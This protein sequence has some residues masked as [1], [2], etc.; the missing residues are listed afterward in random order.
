MLPEIKVMNH[1]CRFLCPEMHCGCHGLSRMFLKPKIASD[2]SLLQQRFA[3]NCV[4]SVLL[5]Q[6]KLSLLRCYVIPQKILFALTIPGVVGW[7]R[8]SRHF[9]TFAVFYE[10]DMISSNNHPTER[11][12]EFVDFHHKSLV[13][14]NLENKVEPPVSYHP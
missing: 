7:G 8:Y 5:R 6:N 4:V 2:H 10:Q 14:H 1:N 11:M 3:V 12:S 9:T 13:R